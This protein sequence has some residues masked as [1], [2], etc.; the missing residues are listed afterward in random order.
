MSPKMPL[1]NYSNPRSP[2][3]AIRMVPKLALFS[4]V[5]TT[6]APT[7]SPPPRN[8]PPVTAHS[9]Q[10]QKPSTLQRHPVPP[11]PMDQWRRPSP[12]PSPPTPPLPLQLLPGSVTLTAWPSAAGHQRA[13]VRL[14]SKGGGRSE[15]H[16]SCR[17]CCGRLW[18]LVCAVRLSRA[19]VGLH[20]SCIQVGVGVLELGAVVLESWVNS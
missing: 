15:T 19:A 11:S 16:S 1:Y 4:C 12:G 14:P 20:T 9:S 2:L 13:T 5:A 8:Q 7:W 6:P 17:E 10:P 18:T 3:I